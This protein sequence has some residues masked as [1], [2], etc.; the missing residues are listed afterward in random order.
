MRV[1]DH[2]TN[3]MAKNTGLP[4]YMNNVDGTYKNRLLDALDKK[5][6]EDDFDSISS[7]DN[8]KTKE[9]K[10]AADKMNELVGVFDE[11]REEAKLYEEARKDGDLSE[12][13]KKTKS[14]A[15]QFNSLLKSLEG[16]NGG[17]FDLYKTELKNA[18]LDLRDS[19]ILMGISFD[20]NGFMS[21]DDD[22]LK[23]IDIN[24]FKNNMDI[25]SHKVG[26][27][28]GRISENA[29]AIEESLSNRYD[30][31]GNMFSQGTSMYDFWG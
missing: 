14:F 25:F 19:F 6:V 27:L 17:L 13:V 7:G 24:E 29:N 2:M 9:I 18:S 3:E 22:K 15:T 12:I 23:A 30:A 21:V 31:M 20:K 16:D 1:T 26:F 28:S 4:I 11:E 8:K 5:S 10:K